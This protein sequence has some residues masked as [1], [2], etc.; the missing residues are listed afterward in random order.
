MVM[1]ET[2]LS[3]SQRHWVQSGLQ[4]QPTF[5]GTLRK[6][7]IYYSNGE[8]K[9]ENL[10]SVIVNRLRW[11][12]DTFKASTR[13]FEKAEYLA[14]NYQWDPADTLATSN[15]VTNAAGTV[16]LQKGNPY[17][18]W[19][20]V[21]YLFHEPGFYKYGKEPL[22]SID[23]SVEEQIA[24]QVSMND[25]LHQLKTIEDFLV[26]R[27]DLKPLKQHTSIF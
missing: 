24:A 16:L 11:N 6:Y 9:I 7:R 20:G 5:N 3:M 10:E 14:A 17:Q 27:I 26:S 2:P 8:G 19:K 22:F 13:L 18:I 1:S 21:E 23:R 4:Q 15:N 25:M 12:I